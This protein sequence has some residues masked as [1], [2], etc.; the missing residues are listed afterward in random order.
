MSHQ[1]TNILIVGV[2][3]QGVILASE[4]LCEAAMSAGFDVKK[5]EI[6]GM[7]QR[8][9]VVSSHVRFGPKVQSPL[10]PNGQADVVLAF[11]AAEG[12]RWASQVKPDGALVMNTQRIVP[13]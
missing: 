9:G 1:T 12:L 8:G 2:G 10:I 13:P 11:E 4:L 5:S 7:A 3:G 6:H